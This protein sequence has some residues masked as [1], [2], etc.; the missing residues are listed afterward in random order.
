M[1]NLIQ[2]SNN[3]SNTSASLYQY[4][5]DELAVHG[6]GSTVEFNEASST[7]SFNFKANITG[8]IGD[9]GRKMLK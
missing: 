5:R 2:Q 1:Y 4:W 8:P 7:K 9:N 3:C 6:N